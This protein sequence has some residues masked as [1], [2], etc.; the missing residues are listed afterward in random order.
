MGAVAENGGNLFLSN[1]RILTRGTYG[2]GLYGDTYG[3]VGME[4]G[5]IE[6]NGANATGAGVFN[7]SDLFLSDTQIFTHGSSARGVAVNG[8]ST[9]TAQNTT[10]ST[11]GASSHGVQLVDSGSS[12][13]IDGSTI[14]TGGKGATG[15][16]VS[17]GSIQIDNSSIETAGINSNG[18]TS[19]GTAGP[20]VVSISDSSVQTHADGSYGLDARNGGS[21]NANNVTIKTAGGVYTNGSLMQDSA[22]VV[23]EFGGTVMLNGTNTIET[24]GEHAVGLYAQTDDSAVPAAITARGTTAIQTQ[25][26]NA[27][28]VESYGNGALVDASGLYVSTSGDGAAGAQTYAGELRIANSQLATTGAFAAGLNVNQGGSASLANATVSTQ[29]GESSGVRVTQGTASLD[30]VQVETSGN[31]AYGLD[32]NGV[33]ASLNANNV[34]VKTSGALA[35]D[36]TAAVGVVA[37]FGGA[38]TLTGNSDVVTSGNSAIGLLSQAGGATMSPTTLIADGTNGLIRVSTSGAGAYG[39]QACSLQAGSGD[40][41]VTEN[42]TA[43]A[44]VSPAVGVNLSQVTVNTSGEKAY[45]LYAVNS[46]ASIQ[47]D[48]IQVATSGQGAAALRVHNGAQVVL[49]QSSLQSD[50][51]DAAGILLGG[52]DMQFSNKVTLAGTSV[53]SGQAEAIRSVGG[54]SQIALTDGSVIAGGTATAINVTSGPGG[55]PGQLDVSA[56]GNVIVGGDVIATTGSLINLDLADG[57]LLQGAMRNGNTMSVDSTSRWLITGN[58]D[59]TNLH[60]AGTAA[61]ASPGDAGPKTLTVRGDYVGQNGTIVLNTYMGDDT[62]PTD[63]LVI[64]GGHASGTTG[65]VVLQTG[66]GGAQTQQGIRVVEAVNGGT[67]DAGAFTLDPRSDGYRQGKGTLAAGAYDYALQR[68]TASVP[69]TRTGAPSDDWYLV[70]ASNVPPPEDP[71][72]PGEGESGATPAPDPIAP[73]SPVRPEVG[74]YFGNRYAAQTLMQHTLRDRQGQATDPY[75]ASAQAGGEGT[76]WARIVGTESRRSSDGGLRL[77]DARRLIHVGSDLARW[78]VGAQGS[79]RAGVMGAYGSATNWS[80]TTLGSARGTVEGYSAGAYATWFG[81][82][83]Q[84]SGPYVDAWL[85]YGGFRNTVGGGGLATESYRSGVWNTSLETG[86]SLP[87]FDNGLTRLFVEPQAQLL[88]TRYNAGDHTEAGNTIVS[89]Q[90]VSSV[91]TRLGVRVHGHAS[92]SNAAPVLQPFAEVNWWHGKGAQSMRFNADV[93]TDALPRDRFEGKLGVQG[94]ITKRLSA[95]G[96][97]GFE[98]GSQGYSAGKAQLAVKY[99]W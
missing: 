21:I 79:V 43:T 50:G 28:G 57:S 85:A 51:D 81:H 47:A 87:V 78:D 67:T 86:Y 80:K 59:M 48:T 61:F 93:V 63:K 54:V 52:G 19:A 22:A 62:S 20:S 56:R 3:V 1:S 27:S 83:D 7:H 33:Q 13:S 75:A 14:T 55:V 35:A 69:T 26:A 89:N 94:Q 12:G 64:D 6:T 88:Y 73:T 18:V 23:A 71:S 42:V 76:G 77:D 74:A 53:Y 84:L 8:A 92:D 32:A 30:T 68:G 29:G 97:L 99:A 60:L 98:S 39:V 66:G 96:S 49:S 36:G 70:S 82:K 5:R 4:S 17:G 65:L 72:S 34:I 15:I 9:L 31:G 38:L 41:C 16:L 11:Q 45:G 91:T 37:E 90:G 46:G 95:Y 10:I 44:G 58:S 2:V 25:G 24:S 40:T